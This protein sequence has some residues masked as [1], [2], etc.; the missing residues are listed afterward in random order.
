VGESTACL[1]APAS[2]PT[3][4]YDPPYPPWHT[5]STTHPPT[6][7]IHPPPQCMQTHKLSCAVCGG[8]GV[9]GILVLFWQPPPSSYELRSHALPL[10]APP[11]PPSLHQHTDKP[12][13]PA[14]TTTMA[15]TKQTARKSTGGKAPRK[16]LAT[17]VRKG[18]PGGRK[19]GREGGEGRRAGW[20]ASHQCTV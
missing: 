11:L 6:Q 5:P 1:P 19:G 17:K 10:L 20:T 13:S 7:T 9:F 8:V 3:A 18:R 12:T 4:V 15:R 14:A 2:P 16:Q